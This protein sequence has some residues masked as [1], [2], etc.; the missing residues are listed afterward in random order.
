VSGV[1]EPDD[2]L[3][4]TVVIECKAGRQHACTVEPLIRKERILKGTFEFQQKS[5][6]ERD[7]NDR[8]NDADAIVRPSA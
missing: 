7:G 3:P 1:R 4:I 5:G 6:S 8:K 2:R